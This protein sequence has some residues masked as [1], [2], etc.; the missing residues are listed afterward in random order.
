MAHEIKNLK[1]MLSSSRAS[2]RGPSAVPNF[3]MVPVDFILE[4]IFLMG[5]CSLWITFFGTRH[6]VIYHAVS[7]YK[8]RR[9]VTLFELHSHL[10][11]DI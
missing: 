7:I 10:C 5:G 4:H 3:L 1:D 8:V 2:S 6:T 11:S 9:G